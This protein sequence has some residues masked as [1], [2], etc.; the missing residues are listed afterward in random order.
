M[1][2]TFSRAFGRDEE[3]ITP[4]QSPPPSQ[5]VGTEGSVGVY[6][7]GQQ[8][9]ASTSSNTT[10]PC[11]A[12]GDAG[13]LSAFW[14]GAFGEQYTKRNV[15]SDALVEKRASALRRLLC[16]SHDAGHP[17]VT[18]V[19]EF[20]CN[21][22]MNLSAFRVAFSSIFPGRALTTTGLDI[23]DAAL[24]TADGL[25]GTETQFL[26]E[27]ISKE[28]EK[29]D[30]RSLAHM[31]R[32]LDESCMSLLVTFV[33]VLIHLDTAGMLQALRSALLLHPRYVLIAEYESI[34]HREHEVVYRGNTGCLF[35]RNYGDVFRSVATLCDVHD[36]T[37]LYT[38]FWSRESDGYDNLAYHLFKCCY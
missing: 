18:D 30:P 14:A 19:I 9:S 22:G 26:K 17:I 23:S 29:W 27:D 35:K 31:D 36:I 6:E 33:G 5:C 8:G 10:A 7:E 1:G 34:D 16:V 2:E 38:G 20:G 32:L 28:F 15:F 21:V 12:D 37:E 13:S 24:E 25:G 11:A 3:T 4:I